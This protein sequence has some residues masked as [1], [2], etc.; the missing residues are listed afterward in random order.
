MVI[1]N[2][3]RSR[4]DYGVP[5]EQKRSVAA[6]QRD[7]KRKVFGDWWVEQGVFALGGACISAKRD[8]ERP[9]SRRRRKG[10]LEAGTG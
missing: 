6:V 7:G 9:F 8:F 2:N 10:E 4:E 1:R 5:N 3:T